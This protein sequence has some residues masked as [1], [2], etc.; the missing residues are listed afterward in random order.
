MYSSSGEIAIWEGPK[1]FS[2]VSPGSP[3]SLIFSASSTGPILATNS[4]V[5]SLTIFP[6][7]SAPP[8]KNLFFLYFLVFLTLVLSFIFLLILELFDLTLFIFIILLLF[9]KFFFYNF[10]VITFLLNL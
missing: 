1:N 5:G 7:D 2:L 8:I 10:Y 9:L 4:Y 3:S 6:G